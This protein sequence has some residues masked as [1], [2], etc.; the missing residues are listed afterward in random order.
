MVFVP[1]RFIGLKLHPDNINTCDRTIRWF[2]ENFEPN[3]LGVYL[4][5]IIAFVYYNHEVTSPWSA[6]S[7]YG[8]LLNNG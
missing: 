2:M 7:V 4:E 6:T 8:H 5:W 3:L 1:E